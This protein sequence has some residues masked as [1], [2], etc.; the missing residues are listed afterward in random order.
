MWER[1]R[2]EEID[3]IDHFLEMPDDDYTLI[4][5]QWLREEIIKIISSINDPN[6]IWDIGNAVL[7]YLERLNG[8]APELEA[9]D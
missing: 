8:R 1:K 2:L 7:D 6:D 4:Q 5:S 9:G 3:R